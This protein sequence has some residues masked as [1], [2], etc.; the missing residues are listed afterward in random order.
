MIIT[1]DPAGKADITRVVVYLCQAFRIC[2]LFTFE[3]TLLITRLSWTWKVIVFVHTFHCQ[4]L[5]LNT[6]LFNIVVMHG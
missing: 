2:S 5:E 1:F 6:R 3:G 4:I